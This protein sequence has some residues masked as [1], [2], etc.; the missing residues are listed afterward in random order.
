MCSTAKET[1]R[2]S[3]GLFFLGQHCLKPFLFPI[4]KK[5][6]VPVMHYVGYALDL[7]KETWVTPGKMALLK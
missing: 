4:A 2:K 7:P 1:T 3:V 6:T 5:K